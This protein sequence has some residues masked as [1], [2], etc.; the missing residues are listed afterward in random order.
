MTNAVEI[1]NLY[2]DYGKLRALNNIMLY[3][4]EG[5]IYGL[6]GPNGAGKTTLIK[7]LVGALK[8]TSGSV[9]VL[10]LDPLRLLTLT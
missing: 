1:G 5:T 6:V 10:G 4:P 8:P 9:K 2:K 7:M 3:V